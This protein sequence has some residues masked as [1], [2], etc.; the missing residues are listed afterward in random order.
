MLYRL[1]VAAPIHWCGAASS[2]AAGLLPVVRTTGPTLVVE[3][4]GD[5]RAQSVFQGGRR[6]VSR[7]SKFASGNGRSLN[8]IDRTA[9]PSPIYKTHKPRTNQSMDELEPVFGGAVGSI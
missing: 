5:S 7:G 1:G 6:C 3:E 2:P 9:L 8:Q 4:P